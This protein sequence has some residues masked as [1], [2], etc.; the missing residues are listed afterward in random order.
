MPFY[1]LMVAVIANS[2]DDWVTAFMIVGVHSYCQN[3]F[4]SPL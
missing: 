4:R 2:W 1:I 3:K